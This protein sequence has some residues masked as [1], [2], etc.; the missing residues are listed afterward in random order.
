MSKHIQSVTKCYHDGVVLNYE[1]LYD[2]GRLFIVDAHPE[3]GKWK[4]IER[5]VAEGNTIAEPD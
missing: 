2:T 3:N 1:L 5:W 4:E